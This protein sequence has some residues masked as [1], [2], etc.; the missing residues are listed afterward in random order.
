MTGTGQVKWGGPPGPQPTPR[1]ASGAD[2]TGVRPDEKRDEGVPRRSGG[3]PY[4]ASAARSGILWVTGL[5]VFRDVL[6]FATM[7]VLVR[8]LAPKAYGE[9][10]LISSVM[11]FFTVFSF[12]S[13]LE[14]TLQLR[15][16]ESVDYQSHFTAGAFLQIG[17]CALVNL[18]AVV[19][20]YF[21]KYS[22]IA[23]VLHATSI[24]F[25]LDWASEFRVKMLERALDWKRLRSLQ[26]AGI[27]ANSSL[28]IVLARL[29][30]GVYALVLPGMMATLPF[31]WDLFFRY[32][33]RPNWTW[34]ADRYR[35]AWSYG[36]TRIMAGML[37]TARPLVEGAAIV[38]L[39]GFTQ[40]G[41][42]SRAVGLAT[43][44]CQKLPGVLTLTLYPV[45]TRMARK[46]QAF[47]RAN[48]LVLRLVGWMAIPCA[49]LFSLI[50]HPLVRLVYGSKWDAAIP[51][52]PYALAG[53]TAGAL[54]QASTMLM[55]ADVQH[56]GCAAAEFLTLASLA[57]CLFAVLPHGIAAYL[58]AA[59]VVQTLVLA[60]MLWSLVRTGALSASA[61][62][63]GV[64]APAAAGV[65]A[66]L[67]CAPVSR[68]NSPLAIAGISL[69]FAAVYGVVIR[70]L[71]PREF[72]E[73]VNYLPLPARSR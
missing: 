14:H 1:S 41:F 3:L 52:L 50:A 6:Q 53:G 13:F 9:F 49:I 11:V 46:S 19:L 30:F 15:P 68:S 62:V 27:V 2:G 35:A 31:I 73:L 42:M 5:N 39:T 71:C 38:Q 16:D 69:L 59:A 51:L 70:M 36:W 17:M 47:A 20:R 22:E 66:W 26:A 12:R 58:G 67:A 40:L 43:L 18:A 28:A 63:R 56:R 21:P 64:A 24:F 37:T 7:L 44:C 23:P 8:L 57:V 48:G 54:Y 29:G 65:A 10:S 61:I 4:L 33:W 60:W 32:R 55:L 45:L 25:L 34:S 72:R